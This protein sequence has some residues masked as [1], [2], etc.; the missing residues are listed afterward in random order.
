MAKHSAWPQLM[1]I[2][3]HEAERLLDVRIASACDAAQAARQLHQFGARYAAIT[4]GHEGALLSDGE[5]VWQAT[6]PRI[7]RGSAVGA[8]DAFLAALLVEL[9]KQSP[10]HL[11]LRRAVAAGSAVLQSTGTD[12]LNLEIVERIYQSV[13]ARLLD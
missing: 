10:T 4:M 7:D 12:L 6:P 5:Q 11:A 9:D 3:T 8:G 1:Q 2:C 13:E